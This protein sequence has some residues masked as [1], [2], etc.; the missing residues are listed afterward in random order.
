MYY[1]IINSPLFIVLTL[2]NYNWSLFRVVCIVFE[3][4][5]DCATAGCV[6]TNTALRSASA[7]VVTSVFS[8]TTF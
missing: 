3:S 2:F 4:R 5:D 1:I 6:V 7:R 8:F